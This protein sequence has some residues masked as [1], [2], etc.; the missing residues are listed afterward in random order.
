MFVVVGEVDNCT[1]E[2]KRRLCDV[3]FG[4]RDDRRRN[5]IGCMR[6]YNE[7]YRES[8]MDGGYLVGAASERGGYS[9][10]LRC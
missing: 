5:G 2:C 3:A 9:R 4:W 6:S 7:G 8:L 1:V 10:V